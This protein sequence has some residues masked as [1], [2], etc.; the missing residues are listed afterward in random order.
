MGNYVFHTAGSLLWGTSTS[1]ITAYSS[2]G[3]RDTRQ[4]AVYTNICLYYTGCVP[5]MLPSTKQQQKKNSAKSDL[6]YLKKIKNKRIYVLVQALRRSRCLETV[7]LKEPRPKQSA[8]LLT[9]ESQL[10]LG[11]G[12]IVI[13][14]ST[15]I[16][17]GFCVKYSFRWR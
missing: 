17:H 15:F 8:F 4:C 9:N 10:A 12:C 3:K 6:A 14:V 7:Q 5:C 16:G 2:N 1:V 11:K 13:I